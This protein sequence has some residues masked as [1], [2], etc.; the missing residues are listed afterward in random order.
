MHNPRTELTLLKRANKLKQ[1]ETS[2]RPIVNGQKIRKTDAKM[3]SRERRYATVKELIH[4]SQL[5]YF[6]KSQL[7]KSLSHL[8]PVL[9]SSCD[10]FVCSL[11][12]NFFSILC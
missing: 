5:N 1:R 8:K 11:P 3:C 2:L 12:A 10:G 9:V 4:D 7:H 6:Q